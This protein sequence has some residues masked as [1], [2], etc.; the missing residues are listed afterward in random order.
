MGNGHAP[1]LVSK[2]LYTCMIIVHFES[3]SSSGTTSVSVYLKPY[4]SKTSIVT[5][6]A[7]GI[8]PVRPRCRNISS[9]SSVAD[10]NLRLKNDGNSS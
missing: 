9:T 3:V 10:S 4:L 1:N 6:T 7:S 2:G 8:S 5:W